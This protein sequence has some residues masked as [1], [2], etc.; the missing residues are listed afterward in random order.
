MARR[1]SGRCMRCADCLGI[2]QLAHFGW[3]QSMSSIELS[4]ADSTREA[5][6][7]DELTLKPICNLCHLEVIRCPP[8]WV[9]ECMR[10][11]GLAGQQR[12]LLAF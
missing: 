5:C 6:K 8:A 11:P 9:L 1:T 3:Q 4:S 12:D 7:I 10:W 2:G